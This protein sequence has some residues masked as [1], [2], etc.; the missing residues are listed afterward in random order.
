MDAVHNLL[1]NLKLQFLALPHLVQLALLTGAGI[2][3]LREI[4]TLGW[5][6]YTRKTAP[7]REVDTG[8]HPGSSSAALDVE[9]DEPNLALPA[10]D[11]LGQS[12]FHDPARA[13]D[14]IRT[15]TSRPLS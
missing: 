2:W 12:P 13:P 15:P 5:N 8:P 9:A 4:I 6:V 7:T 1:V 10:P 11:P 14:P 3:A